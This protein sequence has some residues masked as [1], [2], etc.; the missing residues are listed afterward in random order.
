VIREFIESLRC[1]CPRPFRTYGFHREL[2]AITA[3]RRRNLAAWQA[4]EANCRSFILDHAGNGQAALLCGAGLCFDLPVTELLTR[5]DRLLLADTAFHPDVTGMARRNLAIELL[6]VDLSGRID[7]SAM[8][9]LASREDIDLVISANLMSQLPL[10]FMRSASE[11][12]HNGLVRDIARAHL[13]WLGRFRAKSILISEIRRNCIDRQGRMMLAEESL[14]GVTLPP[15]DADWVWQIAPVG[16][17]D[18]D[19]SLE[20][21]MGAWAGAVPRAD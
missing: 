2:A 7:P 16:E 17:I 10:P 20:L 1:H 3:R 8:E 5:F 4:H 19:F 18:R 14:P 11:E 6:P 15:P 21:E 9:T 12:E 13:E